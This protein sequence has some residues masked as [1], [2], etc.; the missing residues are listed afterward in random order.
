MIFR[1]MCE[2]DLDAVVHIEYSAAQFPWPKSQFLD[3]LQ[4]GHRGTVMEVEDGLAGFSLLS[5]VLDEATLLNIVVC[6]LYQGRGWGR[7]LLAEGMR[8][9]C[10][11]QIKQ[12]FL[13]VRKSNHKAIGLYQGVGFQKVGERLRYYPAEE[14]RE[15]A[16][17]MS[18][19]L[20]E[21][22]RG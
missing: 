1:P 21:Q 16:V 22:D 13:E 11:Q 14:G 19:L 15:D 3:S 20:A 6:P 5:T 2:N 10:A 8:W 4:S 7:Q 17:I 12:C 9:L 18:C